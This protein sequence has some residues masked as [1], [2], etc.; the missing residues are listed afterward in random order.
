MKF[1]IRD[2]DT[3]ALT[4][5]EEI[6]IVYNDIWSTAP[7]CLSI[8]PFRIPGEYF[9]VDSSE[10]Y[11]I[12][13]L[14]RNTDLVSFLREK[15][16]KNLIDVSLHGYNHIYYNKTIPEYCLDNNLM[17]KTRKGKQY[18]EEILNTSIITF[19][20]PSNS[21]SV[22]GLNAVISNNLNLINTPSV[23][24][25]KVIMGR[26]TIKSILNTYKVK[27]W[28]LR[29]KNFSKYPFVLD[30]KTHKEVQYF[31]LGPNS[32]LPTLKNDLDFCYDVNGVF[33]LSTHYHAFQKKIVSG[34]TIEKAL[35]VLLDCAIKK[36]DVHF[37]TY[38][39]LWNEL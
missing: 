22:A 4:R 29:H 37:I 8:T 15:L 25:K 39:E 38:K 14:D 33:I 7:V 21:I 1:I 30:F 27:K 3:C 19:V 32:D 9:N 28:M 17:N 10:K 2:D 34:E 6:E 18:L 35:H 16:K 36:N 12:F 13:P 20:P 31:S 5:S 24:M 26:T 23:G 11:K